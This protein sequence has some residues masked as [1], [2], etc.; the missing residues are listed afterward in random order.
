MINATQKSSEAFKELK[1]LIETYKDATEAED[2]F[3]FEQQKLSEHP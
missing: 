2:G 1:A 3:L